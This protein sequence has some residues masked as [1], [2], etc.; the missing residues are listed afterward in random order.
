MPAERQWPHVVKLAHP[1]EF[2]GERIDSLSFRRGK[3]GDLK[4]TTPGD[5]PPFEVLTLI[6]SRMCGKPVAALDQLDADDAA[7]VVEVALDFFNRCH[8]AGKTP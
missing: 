1:I 2:A 8:G 6:A 5:L 3:M 7:A 4:G